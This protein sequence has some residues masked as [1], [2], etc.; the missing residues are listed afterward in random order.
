MCSAATGALLAACQQQPAPAA[1]AKP[2]EAPKAEAPKPAEAAKPAAAAPAAQKAG[3]SITFKV[4]STWPTQDI[5]HEI[6][7]DLTKKLDEMSG[8]R[9]KFDVLPSGAVVPAFQLVDAVNTGTLDGGHGVPAYWFGKDRAASLFGT[10]PSFGLDAEGLLGWVYHGGGQQMYNELMQNKLK[11]NVQSFFHGPMP[12]QPLGWFRQEVRGPDD[13]KGMKFRTVG[14]SIDN[15]QELGATVLALPGAEIIPAL[16][17]GV[18][19][20]AEFNNTSSDKLLGFP[21][22][23]KQVMAQSYHQP[24]EFLEFMLNKQKYDALPADLKAIIRY[25]TMAQ[26]ADF[27]WKFQDRNS[28]DLIEMQTRQGVKFSKTPKSVLEAQLRAWDKIIDKESKDNP[29]FAKILASQK[30]WAE[31]VVTWRQLIMVENDTAFAHYF[32]KR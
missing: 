28:K 25:G 26:S 19:D 29:D 17:R 24:V 5:F 4:Q 3:E 21:D 20:A 9:L 11:L 2:A 31:R 12:T 14:L 16:E 23:R 1:P 27:T 7:V 32:Q 6:F 13:F 8:G 18:I 10:G 30:A 15:Y 22:V